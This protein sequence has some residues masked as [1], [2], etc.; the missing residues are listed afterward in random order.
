MSGP[1]RDKIGD[2]EM[3]EALGQGSRGRVFKARCT[4]AGNPR[5]A[6]DQIVSIKVLHSPGQDARDAER[7]SKQ[8]EVLCGLSHPNIIKYLD[9]FVWRPGEWDEVRCL[10]TE[11]LEGET[12]ED[13][14]KKF[15]A[16][17]EW[18]EVKSIFQQAAAA[19]PRR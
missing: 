18:T 6:K 7:F 2:Y 1:G 16:G 5:V 3:L 12:L 17:L 14:L 13:R 8:A 10:V 11:L 9:V 15:P 4:A 19:L